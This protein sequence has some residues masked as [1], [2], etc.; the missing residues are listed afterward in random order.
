M[1]EALFPYRTFKYKGMRFN[2]YK[3]NEGEGLPFHEHKHSHATMCL[4]GKIE[5]R[6]KEKSVQLN[7]DSGPIDLVANKEHEIEALEN[8]TFFMNIFLISEQ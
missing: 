1:K 2:L 7:K 6:T 5:A 3:A 4:S 8:D